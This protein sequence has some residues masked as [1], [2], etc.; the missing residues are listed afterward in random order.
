LSGGS[1]TGIRSKHSKAG[2]AL[3]LILLAGL[4]ST[5]TGCATKPMRQKPTVPDL[6]VV[7]QGD[8]GMC[9]DRENT[10]KLGNYIIELERE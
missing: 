7:E 5:L 10:E 4:S 2:I 6:K 9:L 1:L 3:A 8:G